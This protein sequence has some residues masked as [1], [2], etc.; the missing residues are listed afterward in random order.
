MPGARLFV[1]AAVALVAI[2]SVAVALLAGG[3]ADR[4]A[5]AGDEA[6]HAGGGGYAQWRPADGLA[7]WGLDLLE[8][9]VLAHEHALGPGTGALPSLEEALDFERRYSSFH[10]RGDDGL[11]QLAE[12]EHLSGSGTLADPYVLSRFYVEEDLTIESSARALILREGYVGGELRLNYV[13]S[14]LLVHHVYA[15]DLRVNENIERDGLYTGGLFHDNEF[16]VVGQLRHFPG[17]FRDNAIGPRPSGLLDAVLADGGLLDM[18]EGLAFN[19]D[20]FH[21]ARVHGNRI[22]GPVDIKLHGHYHGDCLNCSSHDH[23]DEAHFPDGNATRDGAHGHAHGDHGEDATGHAS[24]HE[25]ASPAMRKWLLEKGLRSH[26][27]VRYHSLHFFDNDI[28]VE[29]GIALR[30]YDRAHRADDETA[31][32]EPNPYLEDPHVHFQYVRIE[33][34]RVRGGPLVLD[35]F[36]AEDDRHVL[37]HEGVLRVVANEITVPYTREVAPEPF[38]YG[39]DLAQAE[40]IALLVHRNTVRFVAQEDRSLEGLLFPDA[41]KDVPTRVGMLVR[42][43]ERGNATV[44]DNRVE[45]ADVGLIVKSFGERL[46]WQL[47]GNAFQASEDVRTHQVENPPGATPDDPQAGETEEEQGGHPHEH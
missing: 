38:A 39:L 7:P 9:P 28:R 3:G 29:E 37:P 8:P 18:P 34:N 22:L 31:S 33:D 20:G 46:W 12:E 26:H 30:Y 5:D 15:R 19:F 47:A 6:A 14:D 32:S 11:K 40:G 43:F 25:L 13:G 35:V 36:N 44:T 45:D 1:I 16:G 10:A 21:G 27:S 23:A 24:H 2:S 4:G 41:M 17:E 42:E